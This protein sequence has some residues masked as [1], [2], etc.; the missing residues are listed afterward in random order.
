MKKIQQ[1]MNSKIGPLYLVASEKSLNGIFWK[2]Q[3]AVP[4]GRSAILSRAAK[5]IGEYLSGKRKRF[6]IPFQTEGTV[7]Q[8]SVWKELSRIPYGKT[9]S[10]KDVAR[11]IRR[12]AAVRAVGNANG[13]NPI[14]IVVPCHR[15][16]ANDG[17]LGG[18]SGRTGVKSRLLALEKANR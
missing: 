3:A 15:V 13:K 11:R 9:V 16:I 4:M 18:Y 10:Y 7:F 6:D 14:C 12:S 5:Q 17:S 1:K 2:K 8:K